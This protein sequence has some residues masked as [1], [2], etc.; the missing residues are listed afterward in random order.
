MFLVK[1]VFTQATKQQTRNIETHDLFV[2]FLILID[3]THTFALHSRKM[4]R[5][6]NFV[7]LWLSM[8]SHTLLHDKQGT[9][10]HMTFL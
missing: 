4:Q 5:H 2:M 8:F 7:M 1:N 3:F 10:K 9:N 6:D